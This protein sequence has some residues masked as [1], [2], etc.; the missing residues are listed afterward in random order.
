[1]RTNKTYKETEGTMTS[2]YEN[3]IE[4]PIS[5]EEFKKKYVFNRI[6]MRF[7]HDFFLLL[8]LHKDELEKLRKKAE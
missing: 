3:L 7:W 8:H 1:M 4:H 6:P 5:I 2:D